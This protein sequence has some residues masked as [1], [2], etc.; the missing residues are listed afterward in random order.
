[1]SN[2]KDTAKQ[3]LKDK[4]TSGSSLA[5]YAIIIQAVVEIVATKGYSVTAWGALFA[6]IGAVLRK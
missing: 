3:E 2:E 5:G 1:M 4:L 6:G